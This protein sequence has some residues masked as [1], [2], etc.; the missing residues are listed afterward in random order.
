MVNAQAR[1]MLGGDQLRA[2]APML[3]VL[4]GPAGRLGRRERSILT[5]M[6]VHNGTT[7]RVFVVSALAAFTH[8]VTP[9]T[10]RTL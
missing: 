1:A 4:H 9:I 6:P 7:A 5:D 2:H 8:H 10:R 3:A